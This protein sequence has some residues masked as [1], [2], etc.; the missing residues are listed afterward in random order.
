[1]GGKSYEQPI[2]VKQDPR[3]KTNAVVMQ[4]VYTQT[5]ALYFGAFD[6]HE[7]AVTLGELRQK[8]MKAREAASGARAQALD[9]FVQKAQALEGTVPAPGGGRGGR[10]GAA[11]AGPP[12]RDGH[13]VGG[14]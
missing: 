5:D 10:G 12:P 1:M 2:E 9:A 11:P 3:V 14:S 6:A 7:A 8:A 4:N 13:V